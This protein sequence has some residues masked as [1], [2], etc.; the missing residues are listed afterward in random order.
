MA[1]RIGSG[2]SN[3]G[4]HEGLQPPAQKNRQWLD[5]NTEPPV[6]RYYDK[7]TD[8]W[9]SI[10]TSGD[11]EV[12]DREVYHVGQNSPTKKNLLWIDTSE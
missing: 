3:G 5:H 12:I 11:L 7:Q 9:L 6:L 10:N 1:F 2:N 8:R 4:I